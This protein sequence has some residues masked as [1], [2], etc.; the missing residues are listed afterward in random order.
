VGGQRVSVVLIAQMCSRGCPDAGG[1]Q[2]VGARADVDARGAA[3]SAMFTEVAAA[4][5][6]PEHDHR[7]DARLSAGSIHRRPVAAIRPR[8]DHGQRHCRIARHVQEGSARVEV[9]VAPA[10]ESAR[11]RC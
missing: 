6:S 8:D 7:A 11:W 1:A 3:S 10:H 9:V 4:G 5:S 2:P